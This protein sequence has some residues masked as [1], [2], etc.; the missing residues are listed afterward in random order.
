MKWYTTK[1]IDFCAGHRLLQYE[2]QCS[3]IHGHNFRAE[4]SLGCDELTYSG[5]VVD[6]SEIKQKVKN[7]IDTKLDHGFIANGFDTA[8]TDYLQDTEQKHYVLDNISMALAH[9][10]SPEEFKKYKEYKQISLCNPTMENLAL[11][12]KLVCTNLFSDHFQYK[13]RLYESRDGWVEV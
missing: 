6:F 3:N 4:I 13:V 5:M 2:G 11:V 9:R 10:V 8:L 12:I 7:W 1:A